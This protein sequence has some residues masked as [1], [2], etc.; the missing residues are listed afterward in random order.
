MTRRGRIPY[1]KAEMRW[2]E[3]NRM[4][5]ISDYHRAFCKRFR[6]KDI[7][8]PNLHWLRKRKK[9]KVDRSTP[10]RYAGRR[11]KYS[12]AEIV[13]LRDNCTMVIDAYHRAFC[14]EFERTDITVGA[15]HSMR[16]SEGWK[17]GRTGQFP[18]GNIPWTAGK[19]IGT[20]GRS[21]DTQFK[22]GN[23]P[24]NAKDVGHERVGTH[25]Y[26]EI[27]IRERNPHTGYD[28]RFV[29]K[30]RLLWEKMH[31]RIPKGMCLKCKTNDPLNTDPSNWELIE[32]AVL[33][34][35]NSRGYDDAPDEIKPTIMNIAK[36]QRGIG[37]RQKKLTA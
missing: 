10:G 16:K 33:L 13:W 30:H 15:L 4:M 17:T 2:L 35:L 12:P 25:G 19:K 20:K 5:I 6:R 32:R 22:K 14:A 27:S 9:W 21:A 7:T 36:L 18:K 28:R 3:A 1:S 34:S 31:G 11:L 29:L 24:R 8:A 26:V 23:R 37:K